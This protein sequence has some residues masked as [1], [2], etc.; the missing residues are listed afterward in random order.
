VPRTWLGFAWMLG[1]AWPSCRAPW[2]AT[3]WLDD[4]NTEIAPRL[5]LPDLPV[6]A[7]PEVS[8]LL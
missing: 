2:W 4:A 3:T 8:E 5:G 7:W 1:L 6:V